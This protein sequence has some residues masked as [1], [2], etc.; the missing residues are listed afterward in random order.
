MKKFNS[1]VRSTTNVITLIPEEKLTIYSMLSSVILSKLMAYTFSSSCI[2]F[3]IM[4]K[5]CGRLLS[6]GVG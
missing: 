4:I 2:I 6:N 5:E 1:T 3:V